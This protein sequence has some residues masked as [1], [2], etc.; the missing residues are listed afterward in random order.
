MYVTIYLHGP[1]GEDSFVIN[2]ERLGAYRTTIEQAVKGQ[3][4]SVN[5]PADAVRVDLLNA[6]AH[7]I[8]HLALDVHQVG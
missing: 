2:T 7:G 4:A 1:N 8:T 3:D 5:M 6:K